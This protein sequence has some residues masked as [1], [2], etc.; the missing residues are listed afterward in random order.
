[1]ADSK[2][3]KIDDCDKPHLARGWCLAHYRRWRRNGHPL[4]G[5]ANS[6]S[7]GA[8]KRYLHEIVLTYEEDVCLKWPYG[9]SGSGY[10]QIQHDGKHHYVHRLV[11][12]AV[13]G[14][15]PTPRHEVA[16]SC[17][18]GD[19]GCCAKQHLRWATRAENIADRLLHTRG[20]RSSAQFR[21]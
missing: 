11:C 14:P 5:R 19:Q 20:S 4:G 6:T 8:P 7:R 10:G 9:N 17:G 12:E 1:M 13:N 16:H 2:I 15:P 18:N 3:C 21:A